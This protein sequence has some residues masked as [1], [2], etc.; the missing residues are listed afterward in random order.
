MRLTEKQVYIIK[1][2][3]KQQNINAKLYLFGSRADDTQHGGD[4]DLLIHSKIIAKTELRKI[5][6]HLLA[7][8][9]EQKIDLLVSKELQ[10]PFVQLIL[11]TSIEL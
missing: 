7:L 10:E 6:W 5:K 3:V 8:L 1:K 2:A 4:I 9:G 11:P